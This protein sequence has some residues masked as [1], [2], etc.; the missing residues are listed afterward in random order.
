MISRWRVP[1]QGGAY[2]PAQFDAG[3]SGNVHFNI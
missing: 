3:R 2:Y 1:H